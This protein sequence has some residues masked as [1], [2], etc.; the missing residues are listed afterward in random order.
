MNQSPIILTQDDLVDI[1]GEPTVTSLAIAKNCDVT[2]QA[3]LKLIESNLTEIEED[4]GRVGFE[5]RSFAT[6]GGAQKTRIAYLTEDQ[7]TYLITLL[8][9]ND[10][11]RH[12]K[13]A[14]VKAF[15]SLRDQRTQVPYVG[16]FLLEVPAAWNGTFPDSFFKAVCDCYGLAY[17]KGST[18]GFV[19][20][21]INRYIYEPLLTDLSPELKAKREEYCAGAGTSEG[22]YRLHQFLQEHC[23]K[24]L[25]KHIAAVET[26]LAISR[27][28]VDF[29][30]HF[31]TR[32]EGRQQ[33]ILEFQTRADRK[34]ALKPATK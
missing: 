18:P 3:V 5:I 23:R 33:L 24:Q 10:V 14:L 25:E 12:F 8:R 4:F 27:T 29:K 2:H 16:L 13:R 30:E 34:K 17:V 6:A 28:E 9:N 15:R 26:I 21:F 1:Q 31:A 19:G 7:S 11:V 20:G 32:F 22:S